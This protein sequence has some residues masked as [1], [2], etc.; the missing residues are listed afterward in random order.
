MKPNY[1]PTEWD[2]YYI[3]Q[4]KEDAYEKDAPFS[5]EWVAEFLI[6]LV[7]NIVLTVATVM[8]GYALFKVFA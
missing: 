5:T 8:L 6:Q 3:N 4:G 2:N 1:K 7:M